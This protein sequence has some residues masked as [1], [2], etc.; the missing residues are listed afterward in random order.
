MYLKNCINTYKNKKY[1]R[2][3]Y[4]KSLNL[5]CDIKAD[6]RLNTFDSYTIVLLTN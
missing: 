1:S 5:H 2:L 4:I 3:I 6:L